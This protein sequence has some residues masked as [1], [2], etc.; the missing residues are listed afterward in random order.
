MWFHCFKAHFG[1]LGEFF[2][3]KSTLCSRRNRTFWSCMDR[4]WVTH[5]AGQCRKGKWNVTYAECQEKPGWA[6]ASYQDG[7]FY[8]IKLCTV[9][10]P[11][12]GFHLCKC[13]PQEWGFI[14]EEKEENSAA[15]DLVNI[16]CGFPLSGT[17]LVEMVWKYWSS[18]HWSILSILTDKLAG[19]AVHPVHWVILKGDPSDL[20]KGICV[21][22]SLEAA[23]VASCFV[24]SV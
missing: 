1:G 16:K 15:H 22:Q 11:K 24:V 8:S 5:L 6:A 7:N 3:L 14:E 4:M 9:S 2:H 23:A 17:K 12:C 19:F 13:K 21:L 10:A 18:K 20:S